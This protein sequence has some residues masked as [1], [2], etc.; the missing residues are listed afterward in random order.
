MSSPET[1]G[2]FVLEESAEELYE[3][4]PCGYLT[5]TVD[6]LIVKVNAT[7]LDWLG[8]QREDLI[9]HK[10]LTDIL[11]VGGRIYFETHVNLLLRVQ[12]LIDEIAL[13]VVRK[14]GSVLPTL[15]NA[16]QKRT[17]SGQPVCNRFTI[18]N[19][20]ERRNYERGIVAERDLY[21]TTLASIGDGVVATDTDA[22]ITSLN[23]EAAR[24]CGWTEDEARGKL[25][26]EVLVLQG[27]DDREPID[28]PIRHALRVGGIVGLANHTVLVAK[29]GRILTIDDSASPIRN[30][31]GDIVGCV[32]VFRDVTERRSTEHKLADAEAVTR[33][34]NADL[35]RS[36]EDLSQFA[37]VASHDLRSPLNNVLQFAQL[38]E[39]GH[40]ADLGEGAQLL[41]MLIASAK[42]M[43]ALIEDLL[44][45]AR[46]TSEFSSPSEP[47]DANAQLAVAQQ[48]LEAAIVPGLSSLLMHSPFCV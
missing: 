23:G 33:A 35:Q 19:A 24:L 7:M 38:L 13:D 1:P 21:R 30:A 9:G 47:V 17:P 46:V 26:E 25:I 28:N 6:G 43:A 40:A 22:R 45:Y 18:F 39:L 31:N 8:Y 4:A 27:E 37:A 32:L 12:S 15:I 20:R 48:N 36:N 16:R 42:R 11:T 14:D 29:D 3:Q 44:R 41:T 10:R 5:T 2:V 34:M